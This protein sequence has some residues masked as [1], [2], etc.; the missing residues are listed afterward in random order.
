MN[1]MS[2]YSE[3][4]WCFLHLHKV[5]MFMTPY[6]VFL[7]RNKVFSC[8]ICVCVRR[9]CE[10]AAAWSGQPQMTSLNIQYIWLDCLFSHRKNIPV[11]VLIR[12]QKY[13]Y[14]LY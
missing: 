7:N 8:Y 6:D 1:N 9:F 10:N 12:Y 4:R 5:Q 14:R 11:Y 13:W 3:H 2:R